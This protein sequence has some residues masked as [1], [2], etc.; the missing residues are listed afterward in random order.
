M[1]ST[2]SIKNKIVAP[3]LLAERAKCDF[4]QQEMREFLAGDKERYESTKREFSRFAQNPALRNHLKW[5]ELDPEEK[6]EDL[7]RRNKIIY[8]SYGKELFKELELL[9]YPYN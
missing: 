4:N 3:D 6:Q 5:Y 2:G 7:W 9:K 1:Q 8:E